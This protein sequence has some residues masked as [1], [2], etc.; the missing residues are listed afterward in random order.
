VPRTLG[1]V[2]KVVVGRVRLVDYQSL[3]DYINSHVEPAYVETKAPEQKDATT[4][5][6]T[7]VQKLALNQSLR[8]II[9]IRVE[10]E[11]SRTEEGA[12]VSP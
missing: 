9:S 2:Q 6:T 3:M 5:Q 10:K 11:E 1:G 7:T 8:I 4:P 12:N